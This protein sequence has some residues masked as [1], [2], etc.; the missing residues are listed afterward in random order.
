MKSFIVIATLL[1]C[2]HSQGFVQQVSRITR[3]SPLQAINQPDELD[4]LMK[5]ALE[6]QS[7]LESQV[8]GFEWPIPALDNV[9]DKV[10]EFLAKI[11]A[12]L[13]VSSTAS[14]YVVDFTIPQSLLDWFSTN[15]VT[16]ALL[17]PIH[18][19]L[20]APE[21]IATLPIATALVLGGVLSTV[22]DSQADSPYD[23]GSKTY[24]VE[25]AAAY[26]ESKPLFVMKRLAKLA[27]ITGAFNLKLLLDWRFG[28]LEKNQKFRAKEALT[29]STQL[30]PTFIK[31]GQALSIRTDLIPE[32][33]ALELRQLQDAVPAFDSKTAF[34]IIKKE[35]G[36]TDL[37]QKFRTISELPVASAS[38]GQVYKA[39]LLDGREV[40]IK[41]QRPKV[42][43]EIALDLYLLRL[44][45]PLQVTLSNAINKRKT[46]QADIDVALSL[47]DE[48]GRGFVA[49]VDYRLEAY[50][51]KQ[52]SAAMVR[53][54]L[55]A[56]TAPA[57]VEELSGSKV[58]KKRTILYYTLS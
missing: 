4:N 13:T 16:Y 14:P 7:K 20:T 54:G 49:E 9:N 41:V 6:A 27:A 19:Q 28:T 29:L 2:H 47:V 58:E 48:W 22:D 15:S 34:E 53:R 5:K 40:A 46:E 37:K 25:T 1:L 52:F 18:V 31:L 21:L 32:A 55:N 24:S 35:M 23:A 26:Y 36:I 45:T 30:G 57:V 10:N 56:V 8:T 39:T 38:I 3:S 42:L 12:A 44:I 50:N 11:V 43:G 33:Y 51:T 17:S